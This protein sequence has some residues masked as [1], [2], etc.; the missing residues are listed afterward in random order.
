MPELTLASYNIHWG[1]GP[2]ATASRPS[3][4]WPPPG[5]SMRTCSCCR[6]RGPPTTARRTTSGSPTPS[7]CAVV[8]DASLGDLSWSRS[9]VWSAP[10]TR[11]P[12]T[13]AGT[14]WRCPARPSPPPASSPLPHLWFDHAD[15]AVLA[16][17]VE[18]DG[19]PFARPRHAPAPPRV[20][21]PP[22]HPRPAPRPPAG[23]TGPPRFI[24]DMNMWGWTLDPMLPRAGGASSEA[25]P[26]PPT[27]RTARSTTCSSRR[28]WRWC[29]AGSAPTS[30][31]T[32]CRSGRVRWS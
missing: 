23:A 15:R 25:R 14:S 8:C 26:G 10:R 27:A 20:R 18:V 21:R 4:W 5:S 32:T 22:Q 24:G 13:A 1:R 28:R 7:T 6:R 19:S 31:P 30:A 16:F 3:T 2:S 12:A 29:R 11:P 17:T 9:P